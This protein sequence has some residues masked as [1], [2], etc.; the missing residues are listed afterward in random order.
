MGRASQEFDRQLFTLKLSKL[1]SQM[2]IKSVASDRKA[3]VAS[4]ETGGSF[5][6]K[7][8]DG[9]L[10]LLGEWLE[11][12]D[13][14]CRE[15]WQIQGESVTP[16]FVRDILVPEAMMLIEAR[17][18]SIMSGVTAVAVRTRLEDPYP[19]QHHLATAVNSIKSEITNRY[20]IEARELEYKKA[21]AAQDGP[22]SQ[23]D[24]LGGIRGLIEEA[25]KDTT[26]WLQADPSAE[27][28]AYVMAIQARLSDLAR[29]VERRMEHHV[30]VN[31]DG[32]WS[33]TVAEVLSRLDRA[34][35]VRGNIVGKC[36]AR[37]PER[38]PR[39][40]PGPMPARVSQAPLPGARLPGTW[41]PTHVKPTEVPANPPTNFPGE[42][43]P[44]TCVILAEAVQKFPDRRRQMPE[45]CKHVISE[46]TPVYCGAVV[47][48]T[49]KADEVLREDFGGMQDLLRSLL[50]HN[51]DGP[52]SGFGGLSNQAYQIY[53]KAR[54]SEE[55]RMLTKAIANAHG[56]ESKS[57]NA[58]VANERQSF[59]E[60][61]LDKKGWS[62]NRFA[63]E[64][65]VD[66]HT[67]NGYLKGKTRPNRSTRKQLADALEIPINKLP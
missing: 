26:L 56:A 44:N 48:G 60:P 66:F 5:L 62:A 43:W 17:K 29:I 40:L 41:T 4:R 19:A 9:Q 20:E 10:A 37:L 15:V 39:E 67:V 53:V 50:S 57:A 64:A 42:L 52:S 51:D 35:E 24:D 54:N 47:D 25:T 58:A 34:R 46:M 8:V 7:S 32:V 16:D 33:E 30:E 59:V 22:Q 3:N 63:V 49:M 11:G 2:Q 13:R 65:E 23:L 38:L 36:L 45:L 21:P 55:W 6:V 28:R 31:D 27:E 18:G 1:S 61:I 12:V 14:I